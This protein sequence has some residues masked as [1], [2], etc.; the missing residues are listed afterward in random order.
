MEGGYQHIKGLTYIKEGGAF[1]SVYMEVLCYT[2]AIENYKKNCICWII[3]T[4][5]NIY[6]VATMCQVLC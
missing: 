2:G 3:I 1:V 6:L 5:T 4:T